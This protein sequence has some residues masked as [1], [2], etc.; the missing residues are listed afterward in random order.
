MFEL[1]IRKLF[2]DKPVLR[3]LRPLLF[4]KLTLIGQSFKLKIIFILPVQLINEA[5]SHILPG[6]R[7]FTSRAVICTP[8]VWVENL[9]F[10]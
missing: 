6:A 10:V 1:E 9:K 7:T 3:F 2:A 4:W 8:L 5:A